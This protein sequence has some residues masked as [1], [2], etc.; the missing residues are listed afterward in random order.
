MLVTGY[1]PMTNKS[2]QYETTKAFPYTYIVQCFICEREELALQ[3]VFPDGWKIV[4]KYNYT[5]CPKD[6]NKLREA[7]TV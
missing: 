2:K 1:D 3:A 6:A 4:K 7:M 5:L